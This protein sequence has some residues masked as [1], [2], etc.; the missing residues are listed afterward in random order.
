MADADLVAIRSNI[1]ARLKEVTA[2][3]KPSYSI[4]GQSYSHTEYFQALIA[5]LK[6]I[7]ELIAAS[8][9]LFEITQVI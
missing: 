6:Q 5:Q 1:V 8:D 3:A 9:P 4:D 7:D 2:S